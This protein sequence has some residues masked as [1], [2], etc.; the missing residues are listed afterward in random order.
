MDQYILGAHAALFDVA[1][2]R[3]KDGGW[4]G[5]VKESVPHII[6][7]FQLYHLPVEV[8]KSLLLCVGALHIRVDAPESFQL[9]S[10]IILHL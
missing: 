2:D 7:P 8:L 3:S 10:L 9:P 4:Q 1:G 5:Q 6:T